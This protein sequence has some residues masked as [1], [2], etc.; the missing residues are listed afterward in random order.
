MAKKLSGGGITSNKRREVGNRVGPRSTNKVS[1]AATSML[2]SSISFNR[3]ELIK[4]TAPQV[5]L[6][7]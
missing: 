2:G 3:P 4:G 1:V 5:P 6:R 7:K